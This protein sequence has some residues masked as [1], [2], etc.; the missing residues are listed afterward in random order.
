MSTED[1][2]KTTVT[3]HKKVDADMFMQ[4]MNQVGNISPYV[5]NRSVEIFNERPDSISNIDFVLTYEEAELLKNDPRVRATRWGT[6]KENDIIL[7]PFAIDSLRPYTRNSSWLTGNVDMNWGFPQTTHPTN[8][9][10]SANVVNYALPYTLT[11]NGVDFIIQD[12]GL[13]TTHP[14]FQNQAGASRVNIINWFTVTNTVG[15]LPANFYTDVEGHG[16]HVAST[17]AGKYYGFA[18]NAQIYVMNILGFSNNGNIDDDLSFNMIRKWH[19]NKP[20]TSNGFKRPTVVNMSW[21]YGIG[22]GN[23]TGGIWRGQ[24]FSGVGTASQGFVNSRV[25][26]IVD[27]TEADIEDCLD[28]GVILIGAAGNN[29]YKID[30]PGGIDY[31]NLAYYG[32]SLTSYYMRGTTPSSDPRVIKVG[33]ISM[34]TSSGSEKKA[35]F[36]CTGP[37]VKIYAPGDYVAG[38]TSK[39]YALGSYPVASYPFNFLFKC[40]K[41]SGTSMA[42]PLVA[43]IVCT[44]LEARPWYTI[45]QITNF[46]TNYASKNRLLD[47]GGGYSDPLSLQG[48]PNNYLY[49][50]FSSTEITRIE[51]LEAEIYGRL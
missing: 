29:R 19:Q 45:T 38:A 13:E 23:M 7:E 47:P 40:A 24:P 43:S 51:E 50:P 33:A 42:S 1:I 6:K 25:P 39:I 37:G 22:I 8:Q 16:T 41:V 5:P 34:T 32:P 36:S 44:L 20:V 21:G 27:S 48:G 18:K 17:V 4:E 3:L 26:I 14:E 10:T 2:R 35:D 31:N 46:L 28:A 49:T 30:V 15:T 11:G 9:F 12:T